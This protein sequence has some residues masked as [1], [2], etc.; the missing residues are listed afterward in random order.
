MVQVVL[1][2]SPS[3]S[4]CIYV[5]TEVLPAIYEQ[6]GEQL[7]LFPVDATQLEG[8]ELFRAALAKFG[9]Q[10]GSVPFLVIG[11]VYLVGSEEIPEKF[12]GLL[13]STLAEGGIAWPKIPGL[14]EYMAAARS[15]QIAGLVPSPIMPTPEHTPR[16]TTAVATPLYMESTSIPIP[17]LTTPTFFLS[18]LGTDSSTLFKRI[19]RD[20]LGNSLAITVFVGMLLSLG[21][22]T[23]TFLKKPGRSMTGVASWSF[24]LLICIGLGI[25]LY[26]SFVEMQ[27]TTAFCG[28][29]GDC[30]TVQDSSYAYLFGFL[31]VEQLGVAGYLVILAAWLAVRTASLKWR[32]NAS[33]L[34][35]SL[36]LFGTLFSAYLTFLEP[37]VI[38]ATCSWC[39][40][41]A[42][43]STILFLL[44]VPPAKLSWSQMK[45]KHE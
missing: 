23:W 27:E 6:Y 1:F 26:L 25:A 36:T 2:Y 18:P 21:W 29:V 14:E 17:A 40:V 16:S 37:F 38:G 45:G 24:L 5:I 42:V 10:R 30:N 11:N 41:S 31:P 19:S 13:A 43:V 28:L 9:L 34:L 22:G 35:L 44:S 7:E 4:H 3:C 8:L 32:E 33:L 39:L 20:P 15:T 12:P